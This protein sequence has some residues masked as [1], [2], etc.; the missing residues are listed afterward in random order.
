LKYLLDTDHISFLQRGTGQEFE[1][2]HS[3]I[4]LST[5][6]DLAL[7]VISLHEQTIGC[8]AY[9]NRASNPGETVRG[10]AM[11]ARVLDAFSTA[12][13]LPFDMQAAQQFE[14]LKALKTGVATLDLRIAAI[15][16]SRGTIL[17]TRNSKDFAKITGLKIEDWT[18]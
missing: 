9:I 1:A 12:A 2:I 13:I 6:G 3:R 10:Y 11:L 17:V 15:A 4:N 7:S 16:I 5:D 18:K 8:H 14:I